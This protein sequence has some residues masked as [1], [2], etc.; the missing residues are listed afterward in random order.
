MT[1]DDDVA[2]A[3]LTQQNVEKKKVVSVSSLCFFF[4]KK[5]YNNVFKKIMNYSKYYFCRNIV[6]HV[7][8]ID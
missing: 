2:V 6:A 3:K 1:V 7:T 5:N 4:L 8:L